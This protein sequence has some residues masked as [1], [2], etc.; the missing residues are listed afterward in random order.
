MT[1]LPTDA[2]YA[3][4]AWLNGSESGVPQGVLA[5]EYLKSDDGKDFDARVTAQIGDRT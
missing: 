5:E 2:D 3:T 4:S 1:K